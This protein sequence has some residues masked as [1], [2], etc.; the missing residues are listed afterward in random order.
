[1][2]V[3]KCQWEVSLLASLLYIVIQRSLRDHSGITQE[4]RYFYKEVKQCFLLKALRKVHATCSKEIS[5]QKWIGSWNS[6]FPKPR[7][8]FLIQPQ[9]ASIFLCTVWVLNLVSRQ[10]SPLT[11]DKWVALALNVDHQM[12][13]TLVLLSLVNGWTSVSL[14]VKFGSGL[15]LTWNSL[16]LPRST[17]SISVLPS[18]FT[19]IRCQVPGATSLHPHLTSPAARRHYHQL[20][21]L[22]PDLTLKWESGTFVVHHISIGLTSPYFYRIWLVG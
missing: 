15:L 6:G 5:K 10:V 2:L 9:T 7:G 12:P 18:I 22:S 8:K 20:R 11:S 13:L 1:M 4:S 16:V 19:A 17:L 21:K 14:T 3:F